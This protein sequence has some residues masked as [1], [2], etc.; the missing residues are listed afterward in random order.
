MTKKEP[1]TKPSVDEKSGHASELNPFRN[2]L[3]ILL[4]LTVIFF[5]NFLSRIILGP[6]LPAVENDLHISHGQSGSFFIFISAGYF[7]G[8]VGSGF[9]SSAINHQRTI[10]FSCLMLSGTLVLIA[11]SSSFSLMNAA[12]FLMGLATGVYLPSGVATI[13]TCVDAQN[14]GKAFAVHETAPNLAFVIAPFFAIGILHWFAWRTALGVLGALALGA[15]CLMYLR[16]KGSRLRGEIPHPRAMR[17]LAAQP[18]FWIMVILFCLAISSTAGI[19]SM[20]PLYLVTDL[21]FTT[22]EANSLVA[23]S[24]IPTIV[25]VFLA[26]PVIDRLGARTVMIIVF[27]Y[28]GIMTAMLGMASTAWIPLVIFL[29]PLLS[30]C[31]FPAGFSMLS[32]IT[33]P[34][35]RNL[36]VSL[37]VP[38]GFLAGGGGVPAIIGMLADAKLF[39]CGIIITGMAIFAGCFVAFQLAAE[40]NR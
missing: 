31:F 12:L 9:L 38:I 21:G 30:V 34:E 3:P 6:L 4:M 10:I 29:Q 28:T 7:L 16:I 25:I 13:S 5:I 33:T 15:G 14:W 18:A 22:L 17:L 40:K 39:S 11:V 1:E 2:C 20:L 24:R 35:S 8:L 26:G 36:A 37:A 32:S 23:L 19:Y 27:I